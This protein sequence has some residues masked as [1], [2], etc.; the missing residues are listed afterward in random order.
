[1]AALALQVREEGAKACLARPGEYQMVIGLAGRGL[2]VVRFMGCGAVLW[3]ISQKALLAR[4]PK[5][6]VFLF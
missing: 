6:V 4:K 3:S 2:L 5:R 1:L